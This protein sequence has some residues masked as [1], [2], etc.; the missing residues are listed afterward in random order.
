MSKET[1]EKRTKT[2]R[3]FRDECITYYNKFKNNKITLNE[4]PKKFIK[5]IIA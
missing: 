5:T 1:I 3:L 4:I 2:L